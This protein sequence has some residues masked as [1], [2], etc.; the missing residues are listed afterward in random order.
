MKL[1]ETSCCCILSDSLEDGRRRKRKLFKKVSGWCSLIVRPSASLCSEQWN[2]A[3][4]ETDA[5]GPSRTKVEVCGR[6]EQQHLQQQKQAK[7]PAT[8][9]RDEKRNSHSDK[10]TR[11]EKANER[12]SSAEY[13]LNRRLA[14]EPGWRKEMKRRQKI[15][16][17][18]ANPAT[19]WSDK[20]SE[21]SRLISC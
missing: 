18:W 6:E 3:R 12:R 17:R 1:M 10:W 14:K 13:R 16:K 19:K 15:E 8:K 21:N 9:Q 4:K 11:D 2:G 20:W 5:A 7:Q